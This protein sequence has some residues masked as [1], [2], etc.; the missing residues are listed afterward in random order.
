MRLARGVAA[1][2]CG[3]ALAPACAGAAIMTYGSDLVAAPDR[4]EARQADT[5]YF[6]S[7]FADG[8]PTL[9]PTTGQVR[10]VRIK[11]IAL[12]NP[13]AGV[14]GGE[15]DFHLQVMAPLGDGRYQ[16]RNPGGTSGSFN[17]PPNGSDP[18]TITEYLPV[19]LCVYQGDLVVFNTVGG[20]DGI[21]GRTGP[22]PEGTPL[23]IFASIPNAIVSEYTKADGTNNG[24]IVTPTPGAGRE[25]LMQVTL[26]SGA[27]ATGLCPGG[28]PPPPPAPPSAPPPPPPPSPPPSPP[29][30]QRATLGTQRVTVSKAGKLVVALFCRTGPS[31]CVGTVK[32]RSRARTPT[33]LGTGTFS[34]PAARTGHASVRLNLTGRKRLQARRGRLPVTI[35]AETRPGGASRRSTLLV[36]LR[37]RGS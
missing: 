34:I 21:P 25:L 15:T 4:F 26:G 22:Y 29:I 37:R 33:T 2:A 5:I 12:S 31:R 14:P 20:W 32:V 1:A 17:L 23:R 10:S 16:I 28:G 27:D 13:V 35:V 6:Q 7:A 3:L 18:S 19:N 24:S 9:A 8:R 30:V 36:T 11:G